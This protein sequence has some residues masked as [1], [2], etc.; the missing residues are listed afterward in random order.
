MS[1][2][3]FFFL[4]FS[5]FILVYRIFIIYLQHIYLIINIIKFF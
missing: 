3:I 4:Y 5:L 1:C 2:T